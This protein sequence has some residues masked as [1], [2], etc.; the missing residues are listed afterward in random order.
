[1][2]NFVDECL[3]T[4]APL[5]FEEALA[6]M[7]RRHVD[8]NFLYQC[9][10]ALDARKA[11]G[12]LPKARRRGRHASSLEAST[13]EGASFDAAGVWLDVLG[14]ITAEAKE[15]ERTWIQPVVG[16]LAGDTHE[17]PHDWR[18]EVV[19]AKVAGGRRRREEHK[20]EDGVDHESP[21]DLPGMGRLFHISEM[22]CVE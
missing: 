21:P 9:H 6:Q 18:A 1:V 15:V 8:S 20:D 14:R 12:T 11:D 17:S 3:K 19:R 10:K 7:S 2:R 5:D 16:Y 4:Y 22:S 13:A